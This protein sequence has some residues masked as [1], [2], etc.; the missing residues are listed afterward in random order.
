MTLDFSSVA[1]LQEKKNQWKFLKIFKKYIHIFHG[2]K[3]PNLMFPLKKKGA[4]INGVD[5]E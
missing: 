3:S 2:G 4:L 1:M 5:R